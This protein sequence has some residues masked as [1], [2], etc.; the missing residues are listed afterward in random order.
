MLKFGGNQ[1]SYGHLNNRDFH[2]SDLCILVTSMV[3]CIPNAIMHAFPKNHGLLTMR[4]DRKYCCIE[5]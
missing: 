5:K 4:S 3:V 1:L 2:P